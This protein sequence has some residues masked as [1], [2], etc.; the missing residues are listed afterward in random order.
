M[1]ST[2]VLWVD[3]VLVTGTRRANQIA[4]QTLGEVQSAMQMVY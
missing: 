3:D 2:D 1:D 4:D